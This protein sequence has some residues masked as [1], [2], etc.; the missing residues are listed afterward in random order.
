MGYFIA[1][2]VSNR[3][4]YG[5]VR[6]N[7]NRSFE[8]H[9]VSALL[10]ANLRDYS[11]LTAGTTTAQLPYRRQGFAGRVS[12]NYKQRYLICKNGVQDVIFNPFSGQ[13]QFTEAKYFG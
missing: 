4:Y 1:Y 9:N 6:I 8:S 3:A 13:V 2:N 5:D 12:Y 11:D 7:Y 10:M